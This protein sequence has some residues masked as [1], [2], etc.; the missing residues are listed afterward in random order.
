M[1]ESIKSRVRSHPIWITA[2]LTPYLVLIFLNSINPLLREHQ[3]ATYCPTLTPPTV[4]EESIGVF[5]SPIIH[6]VGYAVW[7]LII[8]IVIGTIVRIVKKSR[9]R[10]LEAMEIGED[11]ASAFEIIS[12]FLKLMGGLIVL[13]I[14][15]EMFDGSS[16]HYGFGG[17]IFEVIYFLNN[18]VITVV[19]GVGFIMFVWGAFRYLI[20]GLDGNN[21][22]RREGR[23]L[24]S[25]SL[26]FGVLIIIFWGVINLLSSSTGLSEDLSYAPSVDMGG[27]FS[28][29]GGSFSN[30]LA[31]PSFGGN[32]SESVNDTIGFSVGGAKDA[33]NFRENIKQCYLPIP[34]DITYEGLFYDYIF[35]TRNTTGCTALFCPQYE[36]AV[37]A[38][39]FSGQDEY[40]LSVGLGSNIAADTFAR[41]PLDIVVVIDISGSMGSPFDR[42]YY[43][44]FRDPNKK[45]DENA[46]WNTS[47]M[48]IA[49]EAMGAMADRLH[50]DDRFGLVV[51]ESN[52]R[53]VLNP[54]TMGQN[55]YAKAKNS[56]ATLSPGGGTNMAAG[57]EEG[58][59]LV[60]SLEQDEEIDREKRIIFLTDAM[61]NAGAIE[62]NEL[63]VIGKR[64][65]DEG[66]HTTFIGVGV[67]FNTELVEA[68]TKQIKGANYYAIHSSSDF[69]KRLDIEF[70]YM[71]A[72]L[73]YDLTLQIEGGDYEIRTVYGSPEAHLTTG[74]ILKVS[75]LFPSPSSGGNSRGGV[76]LA[77]MKKV[78]DT[79]TPTKVVASYT[80]RAGQTFSEPGMVDWSQVTGDS[81]SPNV[82][83]A[84]VLARYANL[85]Q[86]WLIDENDR[87]GRHEKTIYSPVR[88]YD[89]YHR[90]LVIPAERYPDG[91]VTFTPYELNYWERLSR[92]LI[93]SE[94]Y[95]Q[96]FKDFRQHME[97]EIEG[98]SEEN[99]LEQELQLLKNLENSPNSGYEPKNE[100]ENDI[101]RQ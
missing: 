5:P 11:R 41:P 9:Q 8:Y 2:F 26:F 31:V 82:R 75:T 32:V 40:F 52:A 18:F 55:G 39:P 20:P 79:G 70:E 90:G 77:H 58:T 85:M 96:L 53:T 94:D 88:V 81:A 78:S 92:D 34:T 84:V 14:V 38:D 71:V 43:D 16:Y 19:L 27:S 15:I 100:D 87:L 74:E 89:F 76:I 13:G 1:F 56:I 29:G 30:S 61:P 68:L 35:E 22:A 86:N 93:V 3:D 57:L 98:V 95:K 59:R 21:V 63:Y 91:R 64:N 48:E 12:P 69:E 46:D 99:R 62:Q 33:D 4:L 80:D 60:K 50:P 51:F 97:T 54:F 45:A 44:K 7:F 72:P 83:K 65:A 6:W 37:V 49:K 42:Y 67:D 23:I 101:S 36:G 24:M 73:V 47:K 10:R 28:N 25:I 66:I 17:L